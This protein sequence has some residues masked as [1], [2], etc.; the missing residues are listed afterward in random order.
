MKVGDAKVSRGQLWDLILNHY[1]PTTTALL[2]IVLVFPLPQQNRTTL[3]LVCKVNW[4]LERR[5]REREREREM[6][7]SIRE[8]RVEDF[9]NAGL[10]VPEAIELDAVLRDVLSISISLSPTDI[11]RH[12]V[13]RR[14]LKPSYPHSLHQLVYY[15]I[16]H[17]SSHAADAAAP[18]LYWFPS[19]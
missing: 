10:A 5:E 14:V 15:S 11:W 1:S 4:K 6:G 9:V 13:T 18:P 12:L 19:L 8:L 7:K 2:H 16:Y 17:P 3:K